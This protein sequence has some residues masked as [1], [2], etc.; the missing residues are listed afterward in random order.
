MKLTKLR[1][2]V[3]DIIDNSSKIINIKTIWNSLKPQPNI[4]SVYR[5]VDHLENKDMI[6]SISISGIKYLISKKMKGHGH[7]II[8]KECKEITNFDDCVISNLQDKLQKDLNYNITSHVLYFEGYCKD[9]EKV[10]RKKESNLR[11]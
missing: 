11:G 5:S 4:T 1:Q 10:I 3:L 7:F 9:C 8:C 6:N 2:D